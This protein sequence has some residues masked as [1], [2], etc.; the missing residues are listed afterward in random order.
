MDLFIWGNAESAVTIIAASIP[1]LRAL[2]REFRTSAK[3]SDP[4]SAAKEFSTNFY[5]KSSSTGDG[6]RSPPTM[7]GNSDWA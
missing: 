4:A 1:I 7:R 5:S 2:F 3:R 6:S